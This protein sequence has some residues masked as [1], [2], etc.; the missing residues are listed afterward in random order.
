MNSLGPIMF[1]KRS[2][3]SA[4]IVAGL[5]ALGTLYGSSRYLSSH[6]SYDRGLGLGPACAEPPR[7]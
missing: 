4:V 7:K 1:R 6:T 2:P 3:I 5:F